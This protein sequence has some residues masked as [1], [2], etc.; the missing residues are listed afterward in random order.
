VTTK[1]A[2]ASSPA[3][4]AQ[5]PASEPERGQS[6]IGRT[7]ELMKTGMGW[8]KAM[9]QARKETSG[10]ESSQEIVDWYE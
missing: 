2:S 5:Q 7:V 10:A 4:A 1:Q 3:K 9:E 6:I 8:S